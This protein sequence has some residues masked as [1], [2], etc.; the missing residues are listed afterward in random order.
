MIST[1]SITYTVYQHVANNMLF[2][3]QIAHR[4]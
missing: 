4:L 1:L 3:K 2:I